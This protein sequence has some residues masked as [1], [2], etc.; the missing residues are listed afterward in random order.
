MDEIASIAENFN[1]KINDIALPEALSLFYSSF[2]VHVLRGTF[3]CQV[4]SNMNGESNLF[5][6][7]NLRNGSQPK[8]FLAQSSVLKSYNNDLSVSSLL[9]FIRIFGLEFRISDN[10]SS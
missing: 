7:H 6:L 3:E 9:S 10:I 8:H 2:N 1:Y 4:V 5:G